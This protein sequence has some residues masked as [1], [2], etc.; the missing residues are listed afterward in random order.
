[1]NQVKCQVC[2]FECSAEEAAIHW[3]VSG[4]NTWELLLMPEGE[5]N[6]EGVDDKVC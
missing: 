1:M 4:H 2:G 5:E 3:A 6:G